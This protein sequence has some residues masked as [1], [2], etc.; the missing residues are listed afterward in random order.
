M[1]NKMEYYHRKPNNNFDINAMTVIMY[2]IIL[3]ILIVSY[4]LTHSN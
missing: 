1:E 3:S 4:I 2:I